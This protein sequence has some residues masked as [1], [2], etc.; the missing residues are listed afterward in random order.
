MGMMIGYEE[1]YAR[2]VRATKNL[3]ETAVE[4]IGGIEVIKVFGKAKS[5]YDKFVAA[6]KEGAASYVDWMRKNNVYFTFARNIMP[7]TLVT[8][9]PIGGLLVGNGSLSVSSFILITIL[10]MGLIQPLI[11]C[12]AFSDDIAKMGTVI[13]EVI[14]ILTAEEMVRPEKS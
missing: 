9:L 14:S 4:Y 3:N 7:A 8:V 2:A 11:N 5:S 6:T 13:G 1:N 10:A 12:M